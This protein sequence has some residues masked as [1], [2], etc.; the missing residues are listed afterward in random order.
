VQGVARSLAGVTMD[1]RGELATV[2]R[3]HRVAR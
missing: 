3:W 1:L 2:S